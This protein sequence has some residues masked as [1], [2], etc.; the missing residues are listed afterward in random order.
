M[1]SDIAPGFYY[2]AHIFIV[3]VDERKMAENQKV[4]S[5]QWAQYLG[6]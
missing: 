1:H 6:T 2:T 3:F 5:S 4:R